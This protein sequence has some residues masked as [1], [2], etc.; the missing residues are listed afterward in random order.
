MFLLVHEHCLHDYSKCCAYQTLLKITHCYKTYK[1]NKYKNKHNKFFIMFKRNSINVH[2]RRR[3][4]VLQILGACQNSGP[5]DRLGDYGHFLTV[6][7]KVCVLRSSWILNGCNL[8]CKIVKYS[9]NPR[10][11]TW[12][13]RSC[14]A[15]IFILSPLHIRTYYG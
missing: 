5:A 15:K 12:V 13:L 2:S 7:P 10:I 11:R 8:Y 1:T 9:K 14:Y 4:L 3:N 6:S